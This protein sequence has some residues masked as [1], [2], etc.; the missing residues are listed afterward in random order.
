MEQVRF[1]YR[2]KPPLFESLDFEISPGQV[3]GL[4]GRN[5]AGKSTLLK[6]AVGALFPV[7]GAAFLFD[8]PTEVRHPAALERIGFIPEQIEVPPLSLER[9]V[10][11]QRGYYR[12]FDVS[13]MEDLLSRLEV[14][15]D[16]RLPEL[17]YGQQKKVLL[18]TALASG[19][20]LLFL[21]EPTNGLD[22]PAKQ[23]FRTLVADAVRWGRTLVISTHQVRD[24]ENL[25]DPVVILDEGRVRFQA[26]LNRIRESLA[27]QQYG[28]EEEARRAGALA[29][30]AGFAGV[31][32]L[33]PRVDGSGEVQDH[34]GTSG[35]DLELLFH[36][37]VSRPD[38]LRQVCGEVS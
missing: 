16:A 1:A 17:S 8:R 27:V 20:E 19:A 12:R 14:E 18:A 21:D 28:S 38:Q 34:D 24:V 9:Y 25:I 4:L 2:R 26:T 3:L 23:V 31:T 32:A 30:D 6:L 33:V 35:M 13:L 7:G 10:E 37:A 29:T 22:I 11:I 15:R 36:A 5:G